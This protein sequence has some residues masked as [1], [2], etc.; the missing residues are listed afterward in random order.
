MLVD[1]AWLK[2][3]GYYSSLV[4]KYV[5][6]GW[7]EQPSRGAYRRAGQ[8]A[9]QDDDVW[10]SV[11]L[12]VQRLRPPLPLLGGRTALE[13]M[14]YG[15]FVSP[16]G[17]QELHLHGRDPPPLWVRR[18]LGPRLVF[19]R[20]RLF[21]DDP[22]LGPT[23]RLGRDSDHIRRPDRDGVVGLLSIST[24]ERAL[25]E[26]LD[27]VP[28]A[29]GFHE[30]ETL[31]EGLVTLSP[32]RMSHLLASCRSVKTKRLAL[33]FADRHVL[34]WAARLDRQNIDLGRGNR[35][36]APGGRLDPTYKI[37]VPREM[38]AS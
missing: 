37:T 17:P 29:E 8:V 30:A 36:L 18:L 34:P 28:Q 35:V 32:T 20:A 10:A 22:V 24:P 25:L 33:W 31:I 38:A 6:S 13:L 12:S 16:T 4:A 5:R 21:R 11:I 14:G 26:L 19:H 7:L 1:A 9:G 2:D 23:E 27:E 3:R 15:H